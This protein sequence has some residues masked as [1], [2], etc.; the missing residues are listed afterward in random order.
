MA[1]ISSLSSHLSCQGLKLINHL[2]YTQEADG[3]EISQ[4][5]A[6][7]FISWTE[8]STSFPGLSIV[9]DGIKMQ[10]QTGSL[11]DWPACLSLY[12]LYIWVSDT[13]MDQTYDLQPSESNQH[14]KI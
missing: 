14:N 10:P 9:D 7:N 2:K 8:S 1:E 3:W 5:L 11:V 6:V 4:T 12:E 13:F